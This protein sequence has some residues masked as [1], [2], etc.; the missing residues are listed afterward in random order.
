MQLYDI[1][2]KLW[3]SVVNISTSFL[4]RPGELHVIMWALATI[5]NYI[6]GSGIDQAWVEAGM[7]SATTVNNQIL[8][9][10]HLYR[11]LECHFTTMIS[12][13]TLFFKQFLQLFHDVNTIVLE[14][15]NV[16]K[17]AYEKDVS[18]DSKIG[19]NLVKTINEDTVLVDK[20]VGVSC[21][22]ETHRN[23]MTPIQRFLFN[24]I[25]QLETILLFIRAT[26]DRDIN[27]H[28]IATESLI[29][30][31]FAHDHLNYARL[32]PLCLATMQDIKANHPNLWNEF[33]MGNFCITKSNVNFTSIVPDHAIEHENRKMKV[34]G[35]IIDITQNEKAL[36]RFFLAAPHL[37]A[38]AND[39][40][41]KFGLNKNG[42]MNTMNYA[43]V[44]VKE[45]ERML[46]CFVMSS[47]SMETHLLITKIVYLISSHM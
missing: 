46:L 11:S 14:Y 41:T 31:L 13:Y 22:I 9:C 19:E 12:T 25:K 1:A 20:I 27:L 35:G 30:Y 3:C 18:S 38:I 28:L 42:N 16:L 21:K 29:K 34:T 23:D 6:E 4:F 37:S 33:E 15:S 44:S 43:G 47:R 5:G 39:F 45:L 2:M 26:R 7:Y 17:D 24:Y 10:K 40:K 36:P 8:K 32:L